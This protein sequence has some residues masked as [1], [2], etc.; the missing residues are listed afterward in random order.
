MFLTIATAAAAMLLQGPYGGQQQQ[1]GGSYQQSCQNTRIAQGRLFASC[2]D[3]SRRLVDSSIPLLPCAGWPIE[4]LD[5]RL[6]CGQVRGDFETARPGPGGLGNGGPGGGFGRATIT[7]YEDSEFRG[8]A[9]TFTGD[10]AD[11]GPSGFNDAITSF[12]LQG[13]WQVCSDPNYRGQCAIYDS[14]ESNVSTSRLN[15]QISS[16]RQMR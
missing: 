7:V 3:R 14:D 2:A 8:R 5:G 12:R 10:V 16:L 13:R 4:N 9:Q 11:L 15:D 6:Q 1:P